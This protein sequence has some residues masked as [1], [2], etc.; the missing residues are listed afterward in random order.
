MA[1]MTP[2][3]ADPAVASE[4]RHP[5]DTPS[6]RW[7]RWRASWAVALRMA[8]RDL[9]RHRG[10]SVLVFLMVAIPV[11]L[12]AAAATL[13]ATEQTDGADTVTAKMGT[14]QALLEGP[15][16]G[17]V[18]QGPDPNTSGTGYSDDDT[19]STISGY[20]AEAPL[21]ERARAVSALV[22]GT[23]VPVSETDLRFVVGERRI[24]VTGLVVDPRSVDLGPKARLSSGAWGAG[25]DEVAITPAGERKGL[26]RSGE[27]TLSSNGTER[28]VR[29]VGTA[30]ALAL[31]ASA[32]AEAAESPVRCWESVTSAP[33]RSVVLSGP[34]CAAARGRRCRPRAHT[35]RRQRSAQRRAAGPGW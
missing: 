14:G 6:S 2:P 12:I 19:A 30:T 34:G 22:G 26:P 25:P 18:Q 5:D 9:R 33:S 20:S 17:R 15:T 35:G 10:R 1:T 16:R 21:S 31:S 23:A 32:T 28:T 3:L 13:G 8:R 29:V 27:V 7:S 11:L 4:G 24:R